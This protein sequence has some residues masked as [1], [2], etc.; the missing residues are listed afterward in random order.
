MVERNS[1]DR[2]RNPTCAVCARERTCS[3]LPW[4]EVIACPHM[5]LLEAGRESKKRGVTAKGTIGVAIP[6]RSRV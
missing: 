3:Q 6:S 1:N 2:E 4:V 5:V